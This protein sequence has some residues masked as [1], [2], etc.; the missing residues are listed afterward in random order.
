MNV[1]KELS[2]ELGHNLN[3]WSDVYSWRV[4]TGGRYLSPKSITNLFYKVIENRK[5]KFTNLQ[6]SRA[7]ELKLK[8][9]RKQIFRTFDG[10]LIL[11]VE[12]KRPIRRKLLL[13]ALREIELRGEFF[14]PD[15][16]LVSWKNGGFSYYDFSGNKIYFGELANYIRLEGHERGA[17]HVPIMA[18]K[19]AIRDGVELFTEIS[20]DELIELTKNTIY[21]MDEF[22]EEYAKGRS[23]EEGSAVELTK[24]K[25]VEFYYQY[26][27][28]KIIPKELLDYM[29]K[30]EVLD[31]KTLVE[32]VVE[33]G[34]KYL[35]T[36]IIEIGK[37]IG[38]YDYIESQDEE[39]EIK[40]IAREMFWGAWKRYPSQR[41]EN[42]DFYKHHINIYGLSKN[43][44]VYLHAFEGINSFYIHKLDYDRNIGL[45]VDWYINHFGHEVE[46]AY[47]VL[48]EYDCLNLP[49]E[50]RASVDENISKQVISKVM[51]GIIK[52]V[53]RNY[54]EKY[55]HVKFTYYGTKQLE[56]GEI[57]HLD[58]FQNFESFLEGLDELLN[59][60]FK[61]G[62][63]YQIK[64]GSRETVKRML[65]H[66]LVALQLKK[67]ANKKRVISRNDGKILL[68]D[69]GEYYDGRMLRKNARRA[70]RSVS[71]IA[72]NIL[73]VKVSAL[74]EAIRK[75]EVLRS[76]IAEY[77]VNALIISYLVHLTGV[78]EYRNGVPRKGGLRISRGEAAGILINRLK[79]ISIQNGCLVILLDWYGPISEN[80]IK[81]Y[82]ALCPNKLEVREVRKN[83]GVDPVF[84][85][86]MVLRDDII[87]NIPV[88]VKEL[89]IS[90]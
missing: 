53:I 60:G 64:C 87:K 23:V 1:I 90:R 10:T 67:S 50:Y 26:K 40:I 51:E 54:K 18:K 70:R 44:L 37:E 65:G 5:D 78:M 34:I 85:E 77:Q 30:N 84:Y 38:L 73:L 58:R 63:V 24:N 57:K 68:W 35:E 11:T 36:L 19:I 75:L 25:V 31:L 27:D 16:V 17:K 28:N 21:K 45:L 4:L 13:E 2:K 52:N 39:N 22:L 32:S 80:S 89:G 69:I 47:K 7:L 88:K 33:L 8:L 20:L 41:F 42:T 79:R 86:F 46:R 48:N 15:M 62:R 6:H 74:K 43:V 81:V 61:A 3:Y 12:I 9:G 56:L 29:V 83:G 82:E 55:K 76:F 49:E 66:L 71:K 14:K 72:N 59:G